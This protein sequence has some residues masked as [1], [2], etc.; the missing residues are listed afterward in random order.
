MTLDT[1][2]FSVTIREYDV[3]QNNKKMRHSV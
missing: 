2:T 3:Q 1:T